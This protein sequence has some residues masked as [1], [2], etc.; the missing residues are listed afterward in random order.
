[1]LERDQKI[2]Y[3]ATY[4]ARKGDKLLTLECGYADGYFR[5]LSNKCKGFYNYKQLPVIGKVSMD[6]IVLDASSLTE[7]EFS[8]IKHVEL[9]GDNIT[10]DEVAELAGTIGYEIL[11]LLSNR[12]KRVYKG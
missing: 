5:N 3:G 2:G 7:E 6:M 11:T 4:S 9:L 10:L 12:F 8:E 1:M